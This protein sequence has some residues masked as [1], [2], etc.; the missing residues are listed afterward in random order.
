M[1]NKKSLFTKTVALTIGLFLIGGFV[2]AQTPSYPPEIEAAL[3]SAK[4]NR[5]NL[6]RVLKH[7]AESKDTLMYKAACFL[8]ANMEGHCYATYALRDT[9]D[10]EIPFDIFNYSGYGPMIADWEKLDSIYGPLDFGKKDLVN[11]LDVISDSFLIENIDYAFK[12]W[13]EKPW[14]KSLSFEN[15]CEYVLPYRG[16]NEPLESWRKP[17]YEKYADLES[18][19]IDPT[20]PIEAARLINQ[21]VM[22]W[23][24]FD[25]IYYFHPTDQGYAEMIRHG[26]GRCEDMTNM[27]IYAMR[28]NGLAVT[29]DYTPFWADAGNNHAWNAIVT[30]QGKVIPFMG[31]EAAPGEYRLF[32]K[33]AKAYRKTYS[34]QKDNLVFQP[35][36]QTKIPGWL[37]G[38]NYVDVTTAYGD[39]ACPTVKISATVP[40]SI[41]IAYICVFNSGNWEAIHWGRI[42]DSR[43]TFTSMGM[44]IVYMPAFYINEEIVA[45]GAP[46]ILDKADRIIELVADTTQKTLVRLVSTMPPKNQ[47]TGDSLKSYFISGKTYELFYWLNGWKS[48]GKVVAGDKPLEFTD[49]PLNGLY[50]L[51]EDGSNKEERI[52]TIQDGKQV[53]W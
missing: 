53:W 35:K 23:F 32:H 31:A 38:K 4:T 44:D 24:G 27:A 9:L 17:L 52:F 29:S 8:I 14:A 37:A 2:S 43:V 22:S 25:S 6:E 46:F 51:V 49:V 26:K 41:D 12:A 3:D 45:C 48:L 39:V 36:K 40:D 10:N 7:Y 5:P 30:A 50:W 21:D 28:A 33:L 1:R 47:A 13:R 34:K 16:S 19:M 42:Y 18:R 15:F 11:D 20:D